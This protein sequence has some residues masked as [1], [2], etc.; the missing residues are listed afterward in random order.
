MKEGE[1]QKD[2]VIKHIYFILS[3]TCLFILVSCN[4]QKTEWKGT[5][6]E[7][8]GVTVVKNPAEPLYGE[9]AFLLD[10]E[11]P[12]G[13]AAGKEEY[14][15]SQISGIDVDRE[16]NIYLIDA[17]SA[18]I[19]VFDK[20]GQYLRTIGRKGQGPGEIQMPYYVQIT[21]QNEV[22]VHDFMAQRMIFYSLEGEFLRQKSTAQTGIFFLPFRLASNGNLTVIVGLSPPPIGGIVLKMY[23]SSLELIKVIAEEERG[24]RGI[25][26][27]GKPTW[28]CDVSPNDTLVWGDSQEYVL[29]ILDHNGELIRKI[30]KEHRSV[31]ITLED[32]VKYNKMYEEPLKRGLKISFRSFFPVFN[33]ICIDDS[34]RIYVKTYERVEGEDELFYF[35]VFDPE[36]IYIAKVP[37]KANLDRNSVWKNSRLYTIEEDEDGYPVVKRYKVTWN[38]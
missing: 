1:S 36:G 22:L 20:D 38:Y 23:D 16:G 19:R 14:I 26:D 11:I 31:K 5:I 3:L 7:L 13:V 25:F 2:L 12:I 21:P 4:Q 30:T 34:D 15:F 28:F 37:V 32:K 27:I 9:D 10:E 35:D 17:L 29:Q 18:H 33:D 6:E 24:Q 8:D